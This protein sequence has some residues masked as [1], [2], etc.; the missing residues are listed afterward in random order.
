MLESEELN[1]GLEGA[2]DN[3]HGLRISVRP[4]H[5]HLEHLSTSARCVDPVRGSSDGSELRV[6]TNGFS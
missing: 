6:V 1:D 4:G 5:K 2:V 3:A